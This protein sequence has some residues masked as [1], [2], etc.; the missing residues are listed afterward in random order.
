MAGAQLVFL[1]LLIIWYCEKNVVNLIK[2]LDAVRQECVTID[3][4]FPDHENDF[5]LVCATGKAN[6]S[7]V[8]VDSTFEVRVEDAY[9]LIRSVE[10]Y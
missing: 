5:K 8:L 7:D 9:R 10:M 3:P 1:G 2:M 6:S 4:Q